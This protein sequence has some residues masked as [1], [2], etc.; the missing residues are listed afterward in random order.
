MTDLYK[1]FKCAEFQSEPN[2]IQG[3]ESLWYVVYTKPSQE[4]VAEFHLKNQQ[5]EVFLPLHEVEKRHKQVIVTQIRPYFPRYL[6]IKFDESRDDWGPIRSTRGVS[7][8]VRFN[9]WPSPVPVHL[10]AALKRNENSDGLQRVT[11]S[12]WKPGDEIEIEAGPFAGYRCIFE[13]A[14]S[15]DRVAV[16]L[17]IVGKQTRAVLSR[18]DLAIP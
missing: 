5:F 8:L 3:S 7:N 12:V 17:S 9:G 10:I 11:K 4:H 2:P 1:K 16:M 18:E 6:F 14:R 13:A 15:S